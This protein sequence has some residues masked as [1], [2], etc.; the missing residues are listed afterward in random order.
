MKWLPKEM[1]SLFFD[2]IDSLGIIFWYETINTMIKN[3]EN[4]E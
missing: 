4:K 1:D 3:I 2:N